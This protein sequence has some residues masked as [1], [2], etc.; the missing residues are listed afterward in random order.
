MIYIFSRKSDPEYQKLLQLIKQKNIL[1]KINDNKISVMENISDD[2]NS[3]F[4][5]MLYYGTICV[6]SFNN[7]DEHT[8]DDICE[9]ITHMHKKQAGGDLKIMKMK[10]KFK[11]TY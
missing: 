1:D 5:C 7:V 4:K 10:M 11:L 2:K 8:F 9:N 6:K 3:K